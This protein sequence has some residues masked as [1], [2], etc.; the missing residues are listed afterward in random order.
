MSL[1]LLKSP[2]PVLPILSISSEAED[3]RNELA[4]AAL[5]VQ[6]IATAD[7]NEIARNI[8]VEIRNYLKSVESTRT[9]LTK[10]LLDSQRQLKRLSDDHIAPLT[11]ELSRLERL[12]TTFLQA[13]QAR[14]AAELKARLELAAEAKTQADF[15]TISNEAM[16]VM[17]KAQ[18]Q[19]MRKKLCWEVTD[20]RALAAARPDL[21]RMEPNAAGIQAT[22]IPEMPNL[23]AGLKLWWE[24]K[25][26]FTTR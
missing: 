22:C 25:A 21:V 2:V 9:T 14:V 12:A 17:D 5:K 10:P 26:T 7:D 3:N 6:S 23:P 18:G 8:A 24:D 20:I 13:E 1:N 11:V 15:D 16:P 4:L 19:Q